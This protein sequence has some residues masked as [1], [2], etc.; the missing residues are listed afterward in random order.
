[1]AGGKIGLIA[2]GYRKGDASETQVFDYCGRLRWKVDG[3][4]SRPVTVGFDDAL[5]VRDRVPTGGGYNESI[6]K[7]SADGQLLAGPE[8][9]ASVAG[10]ALG[11]DGTLYLLECAGQ[12]AT[13][14]ARDDAL[15][16]LW[17]IPLESETCPREVLLAP[18]GILYTASEGDPGQ[19]IAIQTTSPGPANVSWN[20]RFGRDG[21]GNMWI[22][23]PRG[24]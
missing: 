14:E 4:Y 22:G 24:H 15:K 18:G 17:S 19:L 5:I 8:Q 2:Y 20:R 3:G 7:F 1:M 10:A 13:I 23:P 6:R 21:T 16:T 9:T 12:S 11:A